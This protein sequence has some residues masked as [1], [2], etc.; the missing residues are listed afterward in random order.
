MAPQCI[1]RSCWCSPWPLLG[2]QAEVSWAEPA[3]HGY[4]R[5]WSACPQQRIPFFPFRNRR[6]YC[7]TNARV[8]RSLVS[9]GLAGQ[10]ASLDHVAVV[11]NQPSVPPDS[12]S[13][14]SQCLPTAPLHC[15]PVGVWLFYFQSWTQRQVLYGSGAGSEGSRLEAWMKSYKSTVAIT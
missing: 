10:A 2:H 1:S 9:E 15:L 6:G 11:V 14:L 12:S 5:R 4:T 8:E 7:C 3:A 13:T